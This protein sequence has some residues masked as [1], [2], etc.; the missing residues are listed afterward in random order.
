VPDSGLLHYRYDGGSY[1]TSA[2]TLL[3]GDLYRAILPPAACSHTPEFYFSAEGESS[4]V[5]YSPMDAPATVYTLLVGEY[6]IFGSNNFDTNPGWTTAGQWAFGTPTGGGG[7][8]GGPD[9]TSGHTG[10]YVYGY[11]LS[12]DYANNLAETHLTSSA[13]NCTG[14]SGVHLK[15]WRWLGVEQPAYDHAYVRVSNNGTSWVT[16]WQNTTEVTDFS[17]VEMD[18]DISAVA[19]NQSTV[20]LRWTMGTTDSGWRYCGW[21]ID[22]IQL[23]AFE[24]VGGPP[25]A[26][27]DLAIDLLKNDIHLYWTEPFAEGGV[28]HYV[29]CRSTDPDVPGDSLAGTAD[30][31]YTDVGAAKNTAI[32]YY[33][34]VQVVDGGGQKSLDSNK[35]GEF[36]MNLIN[37]TPTK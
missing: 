1:L 3:S 26:V 15:F 20:Y 24:C 27:D 33:Y 28:D 17:W 2:L 16:V 22:D 25:E 9:P 29:V 5:H 12:G 23:V 8:Y 30:T 32:N 19:D 34:T 35:V 6:T 4:G 14:K 37:E 10:S 13:F 36:D 21:N 31:E 11:N 7:Q 18:L